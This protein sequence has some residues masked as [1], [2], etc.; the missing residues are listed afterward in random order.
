MA[1]ATNTAAALVSLGFSGA[2]V[3]PDWWAVAVLVVIGG[4]GVTLAVLGRGRM[5][6][7]AA[8][9]WG[10]AWIAVARWDGAP[11]SAVTATAAVV[12]AVVVLGATLALRVRAAAREF[13]ET[14]S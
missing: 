5:A 4:I 12:A 2:G 6:V 7:A 13:G 11:H 14:A 8:I 9:V 1:T 3:A 10:L